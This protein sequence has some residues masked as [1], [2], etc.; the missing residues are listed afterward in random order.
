MSSYKKNFILVYEDDSMRLYD[1]GFV[2]SL[3]CFR[4][5]VEGQQK[6]F[7]SAQFVEPGQESASGI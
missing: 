4:F 5:P 3:Y 2:K 1:V 7:D 6:P